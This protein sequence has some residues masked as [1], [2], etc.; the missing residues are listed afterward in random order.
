MKT[1]FDVNLPPFVDAVV[2]FGGGDNKPLCIVD[3]LCTLSDLGSG[4]NTDPDAFV[5]V[6]NCSEFCCFNLDCLCSSFC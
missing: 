2:T 5:L 4:D 1:I 3:T 6:P